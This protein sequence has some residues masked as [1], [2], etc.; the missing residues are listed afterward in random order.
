MDK[1]LIVALDFDDM[2]KVRQLTEVLGDTVSY[3]KV[4]M[5]LY[6]SV[7]AEAV[8]YLRSQ[9]KDV[10]LDLKLHDIPNTVVKSACVQTRLGVSMINVH[11]SGGRNMLAEAAQ[12]VRKTAA[13]LKI[14]RPKLIAVT[15]LTSMDNEEWAYLR[16]G[17]S[18][19][20]QVINLAKLSKDCGL[21][22]V[23]ASPQE[24]KAIRTACGDD[25]LIVT[26]GIRP[27]GSSLNDQSRISTPETAL[28]AGAT[29]LVVGRP[30]T[31]AADPKAA[32]LNILREME[33]V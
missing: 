13:E 23:V 31:E 26:P 22:G 18:I 8:K 27:L 5:Q 33:G 3:Y 20:E 21:D 19:E 29:H 24:A 1:R 6:Y 2:E 9:G 25:F 16:Y 32:A 14:P 7:G 17:I 4:G 30:I 28:A 12:K 10:F 11:A 15:I